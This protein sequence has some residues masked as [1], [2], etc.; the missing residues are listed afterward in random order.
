M[1]EAGATSMSP[2]REAEPQR[3][4]MQLCQ[5]WESPHWFNIAWCIQ[6]LASSELMLH[7]I[8]LLRLD[9]AVVRVCPEGISPETAS[10][11]DR[12]IR[13][14]QYHLH[15]SRKK[16]RMAIETW[17]KSSNGPG[18]RGA[19]MHATHVEDDCIAIVT[20]DEAKTGMLDRR[21]AV[22]LCL[23]AA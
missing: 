1:M 4:K 23:L 7:L 16:T 12:V 18:S 13:A 5:V 19:P 6:G 20:Q 22:Q 11:S 9:T 21:E 2:L 15:K 8:Q 3:E 14:P 17:E 10:S